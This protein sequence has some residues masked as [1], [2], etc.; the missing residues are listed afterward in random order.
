M[1]CV[2]G[3]GQQPK[4]IKLSKL[5]SA[6]NIS[7]LL[8]DDATVQALIAHLPEGAQN[9]YELQ[10]TVCVANVACRLGG[11]YPATVTIAADK[12]CEF[13]HVCVLVAS[14]QLRSPQFRQSI[15]SL[16]S[17]LQ[18]GNYNA[19]LT[20]FGLDPAAGAAKL[21]F[22][23]GTFFSFAFALLLRRDRISQPFNLQHGD[24]NRSAC[25]H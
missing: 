22:G 17:A 18:T 23:D 24:T 13:M 16:A 2:C 12:H 8:N 21:A 4:S 11:W 25:C 15:S 14:H 3:C 1:D 20:N 9:A 19:V 10:A 6:D 7:S 5:L